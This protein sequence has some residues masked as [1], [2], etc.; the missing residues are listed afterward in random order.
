MVNVRDCSLPVTRAQS[1]PA[2]DRMIRPTASILCC[3]AIIFP[4]M[5]LA[6]KT[7]DGAVNVKGFFSEAT[8]APYA[9]PAE[10]IV[11]PEA[12]I[13]F[14]FLLKQKLRVRLVGSGV[15]NVRGYTLVKLLARNVLRVDNTLR[16]VLVTTVC[17]VLNV[18]IVSSSH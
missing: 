17:F 5:L 15:T 9:Q 7:G 11:L 13:M 16:P 1:V 8:L 12:A 4:Q 14:C 3:C 6:K 10:V 18:M 2:V